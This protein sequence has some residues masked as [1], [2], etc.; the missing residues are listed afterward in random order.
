M[1]A[2]SIMADQELADLGALSDLATPWCLRVVATLRIP[3]HIASGTTDIQDLA[4][5][6][7]CDAGVLHNVLGHLVSKGVFQEP[8]PGRFEMNAAAQELLEPSRRLELDL[9]GFG[10]RMSYV[11]RT[12]LTYVKTGTFYKDVF[13]SL[14]GRPAAN[15]ERRR[16]RLMGPAI[17][18][19]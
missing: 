14:L 4:T 12:L 13:G 7:G 5:K 3:E 6:A 10:G 11:C 17:W 16:R 15:P 19:S 18:H 2:Q 9:N 8:A 1:A